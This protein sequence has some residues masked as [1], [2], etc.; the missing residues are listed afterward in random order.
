MNAEKRDLL[1]DLAQILESRGWSASAKLVREAEH[2]LALADG[3]ETFGF[4]VELGDETVIANGI[5]ASVLFAG[6][7]VFT[8]LVFDGP[9]GEAKTNVLSAFARRLQATLEDS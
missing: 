2:E 8:A 7:P 1:R 4:T 9:E 5:W 3:V 6:Q